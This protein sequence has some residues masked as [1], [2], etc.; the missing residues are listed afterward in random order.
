MESVGLI[1]GGKDN[2]PIMDGKH[3]VP[4]VGGRTGATDGFYVAHLD[5]HPA[6]VLINSKTGVDMK[7]KS[8][9]LFPYRRAKSNLA[10]RGCNQATGP[11]SRIAQNA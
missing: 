4:V 8:K 11:G 7:W 9:R 5:G 3:R 2:H 1:P 6:G 10:G